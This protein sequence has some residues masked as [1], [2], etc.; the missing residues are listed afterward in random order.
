ME[1]RSTI[2][3]Q[4]EERIIERNDLFDR[5][6]SKEAMR[7]AVACREMSERFSRG[8]RLIDVAQQRPADR[9][10]MREVIQ[11]GGHGLA[12]QA[13]LHVKLQRRIRQR[14]SHASPLV[15]EIAQDDLQVVAD[16][17]GAPGGRSTVAPSATASLGNDTS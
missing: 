8:G 15:V 2:A 4:I 11:A 6:F 5:F 17:H 3:S 16:L 1:T 9:P 13:T 10:V 14:G 12:R 7:L